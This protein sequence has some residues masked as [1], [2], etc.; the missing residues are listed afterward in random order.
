MTIV[1]LSLTSDLLDRIDKF[2]KK[3]GYSSRSEAIRVA[4]RDSLSQF[5]L[6]SR[7][8][9]S[10]LCTVTIISETDSAE[11]HT[12]LYD[13]RNGFDDVIFGNMHLHIEGGYC[14]EIYL[15]KGNS[16]KIMSFMSKAKAIK[17]IK[18]VNYTMTPLESRI[19]T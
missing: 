1:S 14:I 8:R 10:L 16:V 4:I 13:L 3:S 17:G 12:G 2:V 18:E 15:V 9:G 11:S 5:T 19:F 6:L 7:Q